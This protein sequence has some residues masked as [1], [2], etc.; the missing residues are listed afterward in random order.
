MQLKTLGALAASA[1]L[2]ACAAVPPRPSPEQ[3]RQEVM[4]VER[5]FAKTMA[6]RD[7]AAFSSFL[8]EETV[9]YSGPKPL[10][11]K[12][13][14]VLLQ[15]CQRAVF[16]GAGRRAGAG[17]GHPGPEHGAGAQCEG[18][19]VGALQ[20]DLAPRA[21]WLAHHLRQGRAAAQALT[22]RPP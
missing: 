17:L 22:R 21:R 14:V 1:M 6:D 10:R 18:R 15:R 20:L 12:N 9:F 19:V 7:L 13:E 4:A 3:A 5:A 16:L 2:C 11:G 8:S